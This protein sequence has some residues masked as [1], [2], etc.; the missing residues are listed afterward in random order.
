M[1]QTQQNSMWEVE[2]A[3][4]SKAPPPK[5]LWQVED[6]RLP[7][8]APEEVP[9]LLS[10]GGA[11]T[12]GETLTHAVARQSLGG[13]GRAVRGMAT[14]PYGLYKSFQAASQAPEPPLLE[15]VRKSPN[16]NPKLLVAASGAP[17][18]G[19]TFLESQDV[20]TPTVRRARTGDVGA[21]TEAGTYMAA[22]SIAGKVAGRVAEATGP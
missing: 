13:I 1:G 8:S 10:G 9:G 11:M 18:A 17:Q 2:G 21:I 16:V 4:N 3:Q 14:Y 22:P 20:V 6:S 5:S 7:P 12:P 15:Q 19:G